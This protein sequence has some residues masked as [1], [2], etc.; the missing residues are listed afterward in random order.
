MKT[1][2]LLVVDDD[3]Y[4]L[5]TLV[6]VLRGQGYE[7][8]G[9]SSGEEAMSSIEEWNPDLMLLDLTLPGIDGLEVCRAVR[10]K[11]HFPIVML[12]ARIDAWDKENGLGAGANEYLTKPVAFPELVKSVQTQLALA[13]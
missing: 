3:R 12:T 10:E 6:M 2:R 11:H 7:V 5:S 13:L 9:V 8:L 1:Q 4:L